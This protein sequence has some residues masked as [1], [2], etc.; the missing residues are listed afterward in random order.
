MGLGDEEIKHWQ[1]IFSVIKEKQK[2]IAG[3]DK[4]KRF[5]GR[6]RD[7]PQVQYYKIC[8]IQFYAVHF[9]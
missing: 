1:D 2:N 4:K 3:K 9:R 7:N 5:G 6:R 8:N